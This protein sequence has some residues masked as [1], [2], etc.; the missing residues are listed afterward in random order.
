MNN[1][2]ELIEGQLLEHGPYGYLDPSFLEAPFSEFNA[3]K[4]IQTPTNP[5]WIKK[6][7]SGLDYVS[8]D[9]VIRMLNKAY[10]YRW[11]FYIIKSEVVKSQDKYDKFKDIH[12]P[13]GS[14]VQVHGRLVVPGLGVREQWGS[15]PLVGGSD[16]QEHA[17]KAA[18]TDALKKCASMFGIALDLYGK[19]GMNELMST[20]MDFLADDKAYIEKMRKQL[21]EQAE[22]A[23]KRSDEL[24]EQAAEVKPKQQQTE[25]QQAYQ[26]EPDLVAVTEEEKAVPESVP[27]QEN[28]Q[29]VQPEP[30]TVS[31]PTPPVPAPNVEPEP[32]AEVQ[33]TGMFWQ[34]EDIQGLKDFKISKGIQDN[35]G[36][37]V[38]AKEF[39][40]DPNATYYNIQPN[41]VK[42][43]LTFLE[44]F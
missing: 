2:N 36:L 6:L 31:Q 43:F 20:P 37:D 17:F 32:E 1:E 13:Q 38:Y 26:A 34:E 29:P 18:S 7:K 40:R 14:V 19:D 15:Q 27:V 5:A 25:P 16:V 11:S 28:I 39:F 3:L 21:T 12:T 41:N 24:K 44:S 33:P 8:G 42:D 4:V 9:T 22:A 10:N 35:S 23:K 30:Q